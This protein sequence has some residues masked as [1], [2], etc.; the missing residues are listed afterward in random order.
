MVV[1]KQNWLKQRVTFLL[2]SLFIIFSTISVYAQ[3]W[4]VSYN[5]T[6]EFYYNSD[7]ENTIS[8]G[9]KTL[10]LAS[11]AMEKLYTLKVLSATCNDAGLYAKGVEYSKQ[12][13][14]ICLTES[15]PDSVYIG[16][17]NNLANNYLGEG[18]YEK[19]IPQLNTIINIGKE[20]YQAADLEH[21]QHLSDLGYAYYMVQKPDSAI[22]YLTEANKY[23][24]TIDGGAEDYLMNQLTIS[25]A[26]YHNNKLDLSLKSFIG[27]KDILENNDLQSEQLYAETA[28]GLAL[29]NYS[30]GNFKEAQEAYEIASLTYTQLGF[31]VPELE[32]LNTQLALVYIKTEE[33]AKSD[34]VQALISTKIPSQ[35]LTVS[36]LSLAYKKYL[37]GEL[38]EAKNTLRKIESQ[39]SSTSNNDL[40]LAEFIL[41]NTR[42]NLKLNGKANI[43]SINTCIQ[44]FGTTPKKAKEAE[45]NLVKAKIYQSKGNG[46]K[47]ITSL[48]TAHEISNSL[49]ESYNLKYNILVDMLNIYLEINQ[50]EEA[51][52]AYENTIDNLDDTFQ[53]KLAYTYAIL[54]QVSGYNLEAVVILNALIKKAAYPALLEYQ[55]VAAKVYLDLGKAKKA[56]ETHIQID[57]YLTKT[58]QQKSINY[59]ENLVHLG[60][61]HVI[62]GEYTLA[63]Q[64]YKKAIANLEINSTTTA[65]SFAG[66]YNSYAIFQ[67]TIGNYE[68]ATVYY[69]KA[70]DYAKSNPKLQ[71]D[72]IQNL[73]T[74]SQSRGNYEDAI[75]LLNEALTNYELLYGKNHPYYATALQN[76]ANAYSKNGELDKAKLLLEEAINIDK[77][78]GL[79][80]SISYI[81]KLHNLG[82]MLQETYDYKQARE[83]F[84]VVLDAREKQ[85]GDKHPDYIYALY[86]M[87]VLMQK[88]EAN[89]QAKKYFKAVIEKYDFQIHSFFPYLSEEEKSKYYSKIQEAFTAFQDFA[90]EYSAIDPT[91]TGELYNFQINHKAILLSSSK[92]MRKSIARSNNSQLLHVYEQWVDKKKSLAKYYSV[93]KKELALAGISIAAI[94]EEANALEKELSLK[95][96]LFSTTGSNTKKQ[97]ETVKKGLQANEAAI[98]IIRLKKNIKSDSVWYAALIITPEVTYPKI[99]V[100]HNGNQL[101]NKLFKF[102]INSIKYKLNDTRSYKIYWKPINDELK[103]ASKIY[104]SSDGIY[105]KINIS[106]IYNTTSKKHVLEE[107][108]IHNV[109]NTIELTEKPNP[110][111][112][113]NNFTINLIGDPLFA[114]KG[115]DIYAINPL[116]NTRVEINLIDSLAQTKNISSIQLVG[117][118]ASEANIKKMDSPSIIHIAT[119]GFFLEDKSQ[120]EDVYTIGN[121]PLMRSGLLFSGSEKHF[122]GDH[123]SFSGS[124]NEEDGILTALEVVNINL[125]K[126][127]LVVL[128][129]CETGLGEVK[130]GEGVYGLQRAFVIAGAKSIL[131]SLW[132]VDDQTTKELMVLYYKNLFDGINKFEALN[133]AQ[134]ELKKK[135]N[136][137]YYWGAFVIIGN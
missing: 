90:I 131:M 55:Q 51:K 95:T 1:S 37:N 129:A 24:L 74:L 18:S 127:E 44:I 21:N 31:T 8:E 20:L 103:N 100:I 122:R 133:L 78:N 87:A 66:A 116:P 104:L 36:Q 114:Q 91:I 101:E 48:I 109:T 38:V 135:Y 47:A 108:T 58:S 117:K 65:S 134:Q 84:T 60:R 45:A 10:D 19:A 26:Y 136:N 71:V 82:V 3:S 64:Y 53:A 46:S 79:E 97:W 94:E 72:I 63:E 137:P 89:E 17:L 11:N 32:E 93:P 7:Y 14:K 85:L 30:L 28:E 73:A 132:K 119:H 86:N 81:N 113:N 75:N 57:D 16:S 42:V 59:G 12:E 111:Q 23:L 54:L 13:I 102:Y 39:L 41:L 43:D 130:N 110:L 40:L 99:V 68:K 27:L 120:S 80:N 112:F 29:V 106:S 124:L 33:V 98:E 126:T 49:D 9:E 34:S 77:A 4:Q 67:Q 6:L 70:K 105:N 76:I 50:L 62:L 22:F 128:S 115:N 15:V 52:T 88:M 121:N 61:I 5:T 123:I 92:S 107:L 56:L 35:N 125:S 2:V 83:V 118:G 25:Q 69:N 96:E